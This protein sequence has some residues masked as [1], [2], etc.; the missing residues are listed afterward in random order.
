[1]F[2]FIFILY[3]YSVWPWESLD[4]IEIIGSHKTW[5]LSTERK[6]NMTC[7]GCTIPVVRSFER[8]TWPVDTRD[9]LEHRLWW[10]LRRT[11][12]STG[13]W[14]QRKWRFLSL[15]QVDT[16]QF[17]QATF[18]RINGQKSGNQVLHGIAD[19]SRWLIVGRQ[20]LLVQGWSIGILH[21]WTYEQRWPRSTAG[22]KQTCH[23]LWSKESSAAL[24]ERS[25]ALS[26]FIPLALQLAEG[27]L[28]AMFHEVHIFRINLYLVRNKYR[29]THDMYTYI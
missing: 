18:S 26:T 1:M 25:L 28:A 2:T 27:Y 14:M 16:L 4:V 9:V 20:N 11:Q 19:K 6:K 12:R 29:Y 5:C 17:R 23:R 8:K 22:R 10:N 21:C 15:T 7:V 13:I 3:L 24:L